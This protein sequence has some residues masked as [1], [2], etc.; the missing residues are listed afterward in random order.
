MIENVKKN[1]EKQKLSD[2]F[3]QPFDIPGENNRGMVARFNQ[4]NQKKFN[5][6]RK[7]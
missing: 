3:S 4:R 1:V 5:K 2:K 6:K 7:K